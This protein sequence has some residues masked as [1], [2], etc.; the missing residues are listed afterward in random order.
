[1]SDEIPIKCNCGRF[2]EVPAE[3]A[4]ME[5]VCPGCDTAIRVPRSA[6]LTTAEMPKLKGSDEDHDFLAFDRMN[7]MIEETILDKPIT[8][9]IKTQSQIAEANKE[10]DSDVELAPDKDERYCHKCR[11]I[12]KKNAQYCEKCRAIYCTNC[13]R[14]A[15]LGHERCPKCQY[16]LYKPVPEK[17]WSRKERP[18]A[19]KHCQALPSE[20]VHFCYAC[21][22][23][24]KEEKSEWPP[25]AS[26][27]SSG[28]AMASARVMRRHGREAMS[29]GFISWVVGFGG[30]AL[31]INLVVPK[32]ELGGIAFLVLVWAAA[33]SLAARGA[34]VGWHAYRAPGEERWS[35]MTSLFVCG[36]F[37]LAGLI[38]YLVV[39]S[40]NESRKEEL[41]AECERNLEKIYDGIR[42]HRAANGGQLP[43]LDSN[44][45][46]PT[47]AS[48]YPE[49]STPSRCPGRKDLVVGYE[50]FE[51]SQEIPPE[52]LSSL[53]RNFPIVWDR[54]ENHG[55]TRNVLYLDGHIVA[56]EEIEFVK[57]IRETQMTIDHV[58]QE[59]K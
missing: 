5:T 55:Q 7:E 33:L 18:F 27:Q 21:G 19:C 17:G 47:L 49:K 32:N 29:M 46:F 3:L 35:A 38:P 22:K 37:W 13:G 1:M 16:Q 40:V 14:S 41:R 50:C 48:F 12:I 58:L 6:R 43:P 8:E 56:V 30:V 23:V 20:K 26:V 24:F 52:I 45:F 4:G 25:A 2:F 36:S 57:L 53:A 34:W 39:P 9:V 11:H 10:H 44:Q 15:K 54:K 28:A 42:K 51:S 31:G 59:G